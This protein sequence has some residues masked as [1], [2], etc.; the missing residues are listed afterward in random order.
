[1]GGCDYLY[2]LIKAYFDVL[3]HWLSK[4]ILV[5]MKPASSDL[6]YV[7]NETI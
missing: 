2:K 5:V 7:T 1:M 4:L 3:I 6:R